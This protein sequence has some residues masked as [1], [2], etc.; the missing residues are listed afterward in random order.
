MLDKIRKLVAR[1]KREHDDSI[2]NKS[3]LRR[4]PG[5]EFLFTNY[6]TFDPVS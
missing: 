5:G 1:G 6:K 2:Y 3:F 4:M